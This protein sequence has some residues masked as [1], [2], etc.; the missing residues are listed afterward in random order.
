MTPRLL[1]APSVLADNGFSARFGHCQPL[2]AYE[3]YSGEAGP[4]TCCTWICDRGGCW[5]FPLFACRLL[6]L[7]SSFLLLPAL[8]L[9]LSWPDL[10]L[11]I[12]L[13]APATEEEVS[14]AE[15]FLS[16]LWASPWP[17]ACG[18]LAEGRVLWDPLVL[19]S[20]HMPE[21]RS[22]LW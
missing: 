3:P 22:H 11:E 6:L 7:A 17:G 18:K 16:Q 9:C 10:W 20:A 19:H 12:S 15:I 8:T 21:H 4:P 1:L 14:F 2:V 5:S 13:V